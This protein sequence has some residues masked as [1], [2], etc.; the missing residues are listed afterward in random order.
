MA[1]WVL[2]KVLFPKPPST[3]RCD[4]FP[5]SWGA[6][7]CFSRSK[8]RIAEQITIFYEPTLIPFS[9]TSLSPSPASLFFSVLWPTMSQ[10][11]FPQEKF[12]TVVPKGV[13]YISETLQ[14]S[15]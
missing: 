2:N 14:N 3:L 4:I 6:A 10:E 8:A 9:H 13:R 15:L 11:V 1:S 7:G 5:W 12:D